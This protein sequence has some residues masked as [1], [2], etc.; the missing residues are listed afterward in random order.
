MNPPNRPTMPMSL[1]WEELAFA[2]RLDP[3]FLWKKRQ[4]PLHSA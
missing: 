3:V 1:F 2:I 4:A